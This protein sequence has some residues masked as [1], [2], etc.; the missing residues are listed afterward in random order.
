M[1]VAMYLAAIVITDV[2]VYS[3]VCSYWVTKCNNYYIN[4]AMYIVFIIIKN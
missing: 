1:Y 4:L 2:C 3:Y